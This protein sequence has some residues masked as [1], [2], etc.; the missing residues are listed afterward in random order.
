MAS[1]VL[2]V[3]KCCYETTDSLIHSQ[4]VQSQSVTSKV[5][6][7]YMSQANQNVGLD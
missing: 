6:S 5:I 3:L 2:T 7:A 4:R 1:S